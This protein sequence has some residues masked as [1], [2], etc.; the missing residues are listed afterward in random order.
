MDVNSKFW[1]R[2]E[3]TDDDN[4]CWLWSKGCI[5]TGYGLFTIT[6]AERILAHRYAWEWANGPIPEGM[7]VDH[8]CH[9][10]T[11][12]PGGKECLHRKCVNPAHL[13]LK[14]NAANLRAS[15]KH[16]SK[17]THCPR[18]HEY[19][20]DNTEYQVRATTTSRKCIACRRESDNTTKR[21]DAQRARRARLKASK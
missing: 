11:D 20:D 8:E 17:K 15:H 12:C 6:K 1:I 18:G 16:N 4:E 5:S 13:S 7:V 2:V 9:N 10:D 19:T 3:R 14:T 21:R